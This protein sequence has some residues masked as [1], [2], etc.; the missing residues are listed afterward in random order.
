M[1]LSVVIPVPRQPDR[2]RAQGCDPVR[3]LARRLARALG[4][5]VEPGRLWRVRAT[6]PQTELAGPERRL[7]PRGSF[8]AAPPRRPERGVLLVDDVVTTGATLAAAALALRSAGAGPVLEA[9]LA[10]TPPLPFDEDPVL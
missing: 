2:I 8:A 6:L 10:G 3:V 1:P 7:S 5:R 4:L 9:A